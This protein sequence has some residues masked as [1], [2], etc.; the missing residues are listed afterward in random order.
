MNNRYKCELS[1][2][3]NLEGITKEGKFN[4]YMGYKDKMINSYECLLDNNIRFIENTNV[5]LNN[6]KKNQKFSTVYSVDFDY[7]K[8]YFVIGYKL[9]KKKYKI[10]YFDGIYI[11][12][13]KEFNEM[14]NYI[15]IKRFLYD[16]KSKDIIKKMSYV[17]YLLKIRNKIENDEIIFVNLF[18]G[19]YVQSIREEIKKKYGKDIA[20]DFENFNKLY[21]FLREKRYVDIF[22]KDI[23]K[24][25]KKENKN[26]INILKKD[27]EKI[28]NLKKMLNERSEDFKLE[29]DYKRL[30]F[31]NNKIK[32][33]KQEMNILMKKNKK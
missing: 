15:Y 3:P 2:L 27:K 30:P 33:I 12:K 11:Y 32:E 31:D 8:K 29:I 14:A 28:D 13:N 25:I 5:P 9:T 6:S 18:Y 22:Y 10:L 20:L 4:Y 16:E 19:F 17:Y 21:I 7:L 26:V 23:R 1:L 24:E